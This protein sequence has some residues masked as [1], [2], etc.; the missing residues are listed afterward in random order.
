MTNAGM[1][2]SEQKCVACIAAVKR[3]EQKISLPAVHQIC[4]DSGAILFV[5]DECLKRDFAWSAYRYVEGCGQTGRTAT[6]S[7]R[8]SETC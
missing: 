7:A 4:L 6:G 3:K 2:I 8:P 5:C 1:M